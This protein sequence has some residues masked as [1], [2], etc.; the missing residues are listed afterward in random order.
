[1]AHIREILLKDYFIEYCKF[2]YIENQVALIEG[3]NFFLIYL[4]FDVL[5]DIE[6]RFV[7]M[8]KCK[9]KVKI[10]KLSVDTFISC[11]K[12]KYPFVVQKFDNCNL[13]KKLTN[14]NFIQKFNNSTNTIFQEFYIM[15][16]NLSSYKDREIIEELLIEFNNY[17]SHFVKYMLDVNLPSGYSHL[18]RA[19]LDGY[20][21]IILENNIILISDKDAI[22]K[23]ITLRIEETDNIGNGEEDKLFVL[24]KYR[25][26]SENLL[27]IHQCD[28]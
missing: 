6:N 14:Q 26:I 28:S 17:L 2:F 11:T 24:Q 27:T 8:D 12:M 9:E 13:L 7:D 10:L 3:R 15:Y 4:F 20:K 23:F 18:Y 19:C 22:S 5:S 1:M 21:D 25:E 16:S